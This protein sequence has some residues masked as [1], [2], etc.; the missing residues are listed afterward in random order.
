[1][2]HNFRVLTLLLIGATAS[3][4]HAQ[5]TKNLLP[6]YITAQYAGSTGWISIGA[7]YNL[8]KQHVRVGVQYGFVPEEKGGKL[9]ILST[10]FF[11]KPYVLHAS[12]NIDFNPLDI[13]VK[14]S[15]HFGD[16][17]YINWPARFPDGYYW[18]KSALRLHLATETSVTYKLK[19]AGRA[20]Y[21]TAYL[22][23]N[24]SDLYLISY[25]L[26][27]KSLSLPDIIKAGVGL[28]IGF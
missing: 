8:F 17:F 24:S 25:V 14:A 4:C 16:K 7:G 15:Y 20:K 5:S 21:V 18:W 6:D 9:Q 23:L 11:F 22:E 28:R 12:K 13:G 10:S 26:N 27:F 19:N 1:M 3:L 2:K